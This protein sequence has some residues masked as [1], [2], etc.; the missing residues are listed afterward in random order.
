LDYERV[1]LVAFYC[2]VEEYKEAW[3]PA[4]TAHRT[5]ASQANIRLHF[6][7]AITSHTKSLNQSFPRTTIMH[8]IFTLTA[9][10]AGAAAAP[11]QDLDERQFVADH[12]TKSYVLV[13]YGSP[14]QAY[15]YE[16][17]TLC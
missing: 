5:Q 14:V 17:N 15:L 7:N 9:L 1:V 16:Q 10:I 12:W 6:R 13:G 8:F 4:H 11:T 2:E 3:L